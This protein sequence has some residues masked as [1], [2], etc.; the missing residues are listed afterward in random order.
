MIRSFC[1][2]IAAGAL[3][4]A[5]VNPASAS[6]KTQKLCG[7]IVNSTPANWWLTDGRGNW[8]IGVQG[9]HKAEGDPPD[10][11]RDD[12]RLW[13]KTQA[14]GYG[15]GCGCMDA[16]VDAGEKT[17]VKIVKAQALPLAACRRDTALPKREE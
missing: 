6:E 2:W 11:D 7:W 4:I 10:V 8:I 12:R 15:H 17:V 9:G 1:I 16:V 13:F 3:S 14:S 5:A